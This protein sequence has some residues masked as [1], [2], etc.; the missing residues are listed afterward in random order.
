MER[1]LVKLFFDKEIR[2]L[3]IITFLFSWLIG[4][5]AESMP[6][7]IGALILGAFLVSTHYELTLNFSKSTYKRSLFI[8]GF[9]TGKPI[10]FKSIVNC[11]IIKGR[12][13]DLYMVGPFG[14]PSS[15]N[16]FH[17]FLEFDNGDLV[18]I[19]TSRKRVDLIK[20]V[21]KYR[22]KLNFPFV[23][24]EDEKGQFDNLVTKMTRV[25]L[26]TNSGKE[27]LILAL[28]SS[29]FSGAM[30]F[31]GLIEFNHIEYENLLWLLVSF[32]AIIVGLVK[33][34]YSKKTLRAESE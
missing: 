12:I 21:N 8:L 28:Y 23:D 25:P 27:I 26:K 1:I 9:R 20:K 32:S 17:A 18:E 14:I 19:G 10:P 15:K 31:N 34:Y 6:A 4:I 24:L 29:L 30:I 2:F 3:G 16:L 7:F 33:I 11:R 5:F 13:T 22:F